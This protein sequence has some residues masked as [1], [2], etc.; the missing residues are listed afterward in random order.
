M[1]VTVARY[2]RRDRITLSCTVLVPL[3][4][5]GAEQ[6]AALSAAPFK[7][8]LRYW[9]RISGLHQARNPQQ[10]FEKE[11]ALFGS[12]NPE[13]GRSL[14]EVEV[15]G[16][17]KGIQEPFTN[18]K[19]VGQ[20]KTNVSALLYL[21]NLGL[22]KPSR[23]KH[24]LEALRQYFQTGEAFKV[25]FTMA[26]EAMRQTSAALNLFQQFGGMGGRSRNA[27]GS[28]DVQ[29]SATLHQVDRLTDWKQLMQRDFPT[30]LGSDQKLLCWR[31][32]PK[33]NW[34]SAMHDLAKMYIDLRSSAGMKRK[35]GQ[36]H[37][38]GKHL[39]G[40]PVTG[41]PN[42]RSASALRFTLR[43]ENNRYFPIIL[44]VPCQNPVVTVD[45][46]QQIKVWQQVHC[47]LDDPA[48]GLQRYNPNKAA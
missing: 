7:A 37:F 38:K 27:W 24:S 34:E 35:I 44:H 16:N 10:L 18:L 13:C 14:V 43:W 22:L 41:G 5:G 6:E 30:G 45:V 36:S 31:M 8:A 40:S 15:E 3:F 23:D 17:P 39:L 28:L 19:T 32:S 4:L 46:E 12:A 47:F 20:G 26:A 9:W 48:N 2:H 33:D 1:P 25:H 29:T 42:E 11:S 21:A